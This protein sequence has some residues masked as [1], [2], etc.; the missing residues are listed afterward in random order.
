MYR[1]TLSRDWFGKSVR[2]FIL[3]AALVFL[4]FGCASR[5]SNQMTVHIGYE[6]IL[7][8]YAFFVANEQGYFDAG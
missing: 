2:L 3:S 8:D 6:A 7:P 5:S 4:T 1:C